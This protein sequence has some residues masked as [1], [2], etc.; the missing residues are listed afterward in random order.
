MNYKIIA[1]TIIG[2]VIAVVASGFAYFNSMIGMQ[3]D[4]TTITGDISDVTIPGG[5]QNDI[6]ISQPFYIADATEAYRDLNDKVTS[7]IMLGIRSDGTPRQDALVPIYKELFALFDAHVGTVKEQAYMLNMANIMFNHGYNTKAFQEGVSES[8]AFG[9]VLEKHLETIAKYRPKQSNLKGVMFD[10][11][12][13][14]L[15]YAVQRTIADMNQA[16]YDLYPG[17]YSMLR[18]NLNTLQAEVM[19]HQNYQTGKNFNPSRWDLFLIN[20]FGPEHLDTMREEM[21]PYLNGSAQLY[22]GAYSASFELHVMY[23]TGVLWPKYQSIIDDAS[24]NTEKL[25]ILNEVVD[26][27]NQM[28]IKTDEFNTGLQPYGYAIAAFLKSRVAAQEVIPDEDASRL[29]DESIKIIE[30]LIKTQGENK[31]MLYWMSNLPRNGWMY[32][33]LTGMAEKSPQ[34]KD[35]VSTL[36]R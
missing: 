11:T 6:Q 18:K 28:M 1:Y 30:Q 2:I 10:S 15:T 9:P 24:K 35:F 23:A 25:Q 3:S 4:D 21:K 12:T 13:P 14:G 5:S 19:L 32:R 31:T 27:T 22:E 26:H 7:M 17:A 20:A 33:Q 34:V 8:K 36:K 16:S 29:E